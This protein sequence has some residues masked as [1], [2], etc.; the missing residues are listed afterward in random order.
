MRITYTLI[1]ITEWRT[2]EKF[3]GVKVM[4]GLV[5]VWGGGAPRTPENF[6]KFAKK[7]QKCIIL[8]YFSKEFNKP[9]VNFSRVWTKNTNS[10]E[11]LR[12]F[13]KFSKY[14]FSKFRKIHYFSI[15][16]EKFNKPCFNFSRV[17]TRTTNCWEILRKFWEFL[18]KIQTKN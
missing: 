9:R 15:V 3:R 6:G 17:R 4:A 16:F 8:A 12:N 2:Q 7:M 5:G 10:W 1:G 18:L 13:R 11:I 14:F